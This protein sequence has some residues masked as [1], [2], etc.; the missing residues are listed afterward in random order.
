MRLQQN[1]HWFF[2]PL[3][4]LACAK[5]TAPTGGPK[6]TIPPTLVSSK[7][8]NQQTNYTATSL[9][10]TFDE[11][12]QINNPKEQIIVTPNTGNKFEAVAKKNTVS[13]KFDSPF[14]PILGS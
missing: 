3:F 10:L 5:Q 12:L 14:D 13:I 6:D 4:L 2:Y 8:F 9:E 11:R 7:P 1:T